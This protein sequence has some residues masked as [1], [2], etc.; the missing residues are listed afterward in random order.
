M[1]SLQV[2]PTE[3]YIGF[4]D[5][6]SVGTTLQFYN[7]ETLAPE[8]E[9]EVASV[10]PVTDDAIIAD[11]EDGL[12]EL[13]LLNWNITPEFVTLAQP[14]NLTSR[15]S[16]VDDAEASSDFTVHTSIM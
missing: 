3:L 4:P 14:V 12:T 15:Y 8:G 7:L 2:S 13:G 10:Q 6:A 16:L 9:A 1:P 5:Y 11:F